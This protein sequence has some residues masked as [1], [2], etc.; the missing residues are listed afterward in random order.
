[1]KKLSMFAAAVCAALAAL[2]SSFWLSAAGA[3]GRA[4]PRPYGGGGRG[5]HRNK[6]RT[7]LKTL[8]PPNG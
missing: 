7:V 5:K 8:I 1:M 4:P 3:A 2:F 6:T